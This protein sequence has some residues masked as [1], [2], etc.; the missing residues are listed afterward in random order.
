[1]AS[2]EVMP[3]PSSWT[4]ISWTPPRSASA[5]LATTLVGASSGCLWVAQDATAVLRDDAPRRLRTA[6]HRT[7]RRTGP[8]RAGRMK[9]S[10]SQMALDT[11][12]ARSNCATVPIY[13]KLQS[14]I[15]NPPRFEGKPKECLMC[16]WDHPWHAALSHPRFRSSPSLVVAGTTGTAD[17]TRPRCLIQLNRCSTSRPVRA[18]HHSGGRPKSQ[19]SLW[20]CGPDHSGVDLHSL[21]NCCNDPLRPQ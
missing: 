6:S 21:A 2:S 14:A 18:V 17:R 8:K 9:T 3:S 5:I 11:R 15:R 13:E 20:R 1:L 10:I 19:R 12:G 4:R 16:E 7:S